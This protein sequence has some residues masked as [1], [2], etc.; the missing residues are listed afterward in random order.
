MV[1]KE[2]K[3]SAIEV[4]DD[5]VPVATQNA[6]QEVSNSQ[7]AMRVHSPAQTNIVESSELGDVLKYLFEDKLEEDK[8]MT[9]IDMKTQLGL[10]E[11]SSMVCVDFLISSRFLP[12][13]CIA[14][15]RTKKRLNVSLRALGINSMV[16]VVVG[17]REQDA[18]MNPM[19]PQK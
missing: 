17:K 2:V 16:A 4:I 12:Q 15:P 6:F 11:I 9:S 7:F 8:N 14:L 5:G 1:K 3:K 13:H 19:M 18:K 10:I